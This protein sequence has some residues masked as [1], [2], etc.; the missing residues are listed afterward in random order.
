MSSYLRI[1][2]RVRILLA[3][4][5]LSTAGFLEASTLRIDQTKIRLFIPPGQAK[6]GAITVDNPTDRVLTVKVYAEDWVYASAQDGTKEFMVAGTG[7][8]SG[9][10]WIIFVPSEFT[11]PPFGRQTINYTVKVPADAMG[12]HYAV[13]FFET[14]GAGLEEGVGVNLLV[15]IGTIFYIEPE[16]TIRRS[17]EINDLKVA[18]IDGE[19]LAISLNFKNNGNVDITGKTTFDLIDKNGLVYAR[20]AFNEVYAQPQDTAKLNAAWKDPIP[21]GTYDLV[22]TLDLSKQQGETGAIKTLVLTRE[23]EI[24]IGKDGRIVKVGQLQ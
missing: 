3:L 15:R 4:L 7:P 6:S 23:A 11:L 8:F 19:S 22:I 14:S 18:K 20:G 17:C 21:P 12:G 24:T 10:Q 5:F 9:A 13:L 2:G 1:G 16:G